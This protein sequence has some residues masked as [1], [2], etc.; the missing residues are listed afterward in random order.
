[1]LDVGMYRLDLQRLSRRLRSAQHDLF[2]IIFS[3]D[4]PGLERA[5]VF[6]RVSQEASALPLLIRERDL[7]HQVGAVSKAK[8]RHV[9]YL[10]QKGCPA[11][12]HIISYFY[13]TF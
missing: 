8:V 13:F 10:F 7:D 3:A 6:S 2:P 5:A 4:Q 12:T 1:M 11:A 9:G